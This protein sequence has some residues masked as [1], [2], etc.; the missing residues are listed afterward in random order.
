M[1]GKSTI[2]NLVDSASFRCRHAGVETMYLD[3]NNR[4]PRFEPLP[5]KP[6]P[7]KSLT[8]R[9]EKTILIAIFLYLIVTFLAPIGGSS[10]LQAFIH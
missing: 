7:K 4:Y 9:Q 6:T 1:V 8:P 5:P 3:I 2:V 10:V